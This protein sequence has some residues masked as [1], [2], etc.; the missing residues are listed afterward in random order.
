MAGCM[1]YGESILLMNR[2]F[3]CA[4][5]GVVALLEGGK[6]VKTVALRADKDALPV[7]EATGL[8]YASAAK[9]KY[10]GQEVGVMHACGHDNHTAI[11]MGVATVLAKVRAQLPGTVKFIF[12]PA[13]EGAPPGEDGGA[14]LMVKEG[15]L[16]NPNVDAIFGLHVMQLDRTGQISMRPLGAMA[17]SQRFEIVVTGKQTHGAMPWSGIDPI[18]VAAQIVTALQ[19]IVSRRARGPHGRVERCDVPIGLESRGQCEYRFRC[20]LRDE[21]MTACAIRRSSRKLAAR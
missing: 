14:D 4:F 16:A 10:L 7:V 13:E 3:R 1:A 17:S 2:V 20:A 8:P 6:P 21:Q 19:T 15:V 5:T 12:Q 18:V 11:L 9:D